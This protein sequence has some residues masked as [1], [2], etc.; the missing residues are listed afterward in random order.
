MEQSKVLTYS[1]KVTN[2]PT[3]PLLLNAKKLKVLL[4]N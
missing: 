4:K 3:P 1:A 2:F